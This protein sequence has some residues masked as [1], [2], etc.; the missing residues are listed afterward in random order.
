MAYNPLQGW[1]KPAPFRILV[2]QGQKH[3]RIKAVLSLA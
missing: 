1:P 3:D 2:A